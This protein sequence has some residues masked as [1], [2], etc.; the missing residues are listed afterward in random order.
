MNPDTMTPA[1]RLK[2]V[3]RRF[4][5]RGIGL[6]RHRAVV[7]ALADV[8]LDIPAG[9]R[10]G[11]VGESGSGKTT[12]MRL[13]AALDAPTTGSIEV[14]GLDVVGRSEAELRPLRRALQMV[15]QDPMG[16]LD[17]RMR[18]REIVAEPLRAQGRRDVA[19]SVDR[20]L[21]EVGLDP[22]TAHR[23]PHQF[24]GG[25]RQRISIAR[26]I[27]PRPSILIADEPVSALDVTIRAQ[28]LALLAGIAARDDLTLIFVSHDLAVVREVCDQVV[29]LKA[30]R[31]VESGPTERV[32]REPTADYTREL[33]AAVPTLERSLEAAR[34][35]A[36]LGTGER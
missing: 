34:R 6:P 13:I 36:G 10:F 24:S 4:Q 28:V 18:V 33:L 1:V 8:D 15:F 25:E 31:V 20:A 2:G 27:A 23:F 3:S 12:L 7:D 30:G 32:Y 16:S 11:V 17:P 22:G 21:A 19:A 5:R 9:S 29:V 35:R 14:A 26:A